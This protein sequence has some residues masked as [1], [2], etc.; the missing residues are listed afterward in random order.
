MRN[1]LELSRKWPAAEVARKV[2]EVCCGCLV[3]LVRNV[4]SSKL[5]PKFQQ[6]PII[7]LVVTSLMYSL[8]QNS[9]FSPF[10]FCFPLNIIIFQGSLDHLHTVIF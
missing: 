3:Y 9:F 6:D 1:A 2:P 10:F 7:G 4:C 8:F 5:S